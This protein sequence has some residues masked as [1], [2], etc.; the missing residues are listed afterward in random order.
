[1]SNHTKRS[2]LSPG[3]AA[4]TSDI[5]IKYDLIKTQNKELTQQNKNLIN[6]LN[7]SKKRLLQIAKEKNILLDKL[8]FLQQQQ[9]QQNKDSSNLEEVHQQQEVVSPNSPTPT[10]TISL[11]TNENYTFSK[12]DREPIV[13]DNS[14]VVNSSRPKRMRKDPV[15]SKLRR[16][17]PLE[18]DANGQ[19]ILPARVGIITVHS[20]GKVV[21]I[22]TYHNDRYIW[23]PGFK[24]SRTYL[25]MV[26]PTLNTTYTCSVEENGEQGPKFR[27]IAEDSPDNPIVANSATGVWTAIVKSANEIRNREHSNSASG[28]DYY[29]F[30][31]A[32]IAKM[33]QDLPN[34]DQC[35]NYVWQ[36]FDTM[37]QRTAAGVAAAAQKKIANLEIMGSANKKPSKADI[38]AALSNGP[39][40]FSPSTLLYDKQHLQKEHPQQQ[41]L[42]QD[43]AAA[44]AEPVKYYKKSSLHEIMNTPDELESQQKQ[45]QDSKMWNNTNF[46]Y[47]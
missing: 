6:D 5:Q 47:V 43:T 20:L 16:V 8:L 45:Q 14:K 38:S 34:A 18:R 30:T 22:P 46:H 32:T 9:Q 12:R 3:T 33:I 42:Q 21:P 23:P 41:Q 13:E 17:Q 28:P 19:Y 2:K 27:V 1:M 35:E 10:N 37:H 4:A 15:E 11:S 39:E 24:I 31:H 25:S 26:N 7:R 40:G 44:K 36:K 29:G